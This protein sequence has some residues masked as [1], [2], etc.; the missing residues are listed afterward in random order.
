VLPD[1]RTLDFIWDTVWWRR[2]AY[3]ATLMSTACLLLYP[4]IFDA[5]M[6][7]ADDNPITRVAGLATAVVPSPAHPWIDS[8]RSDPFTVVLLAAMTGVF[9]LW[10]SL[11]DRRIHDRALAAWNGKSRANRFHWFQESLRQRFLA[12]IFTVLLFP[13]SAVFGIVAL[14]FD[15]SGTGLVLLLISVLSL[16]PAIVS[17]IYTYVLWRMRKLGL[18]EKTEIR[19]FGLW[20]ASKLRQSKLTAGPYRF[21]AWQILPRVFAIALVAASFVAASRI[22]FDFMDSG[23]WVCE[24]GSVVQIPK[25]GLSVDFTPDRPCQ[26]TNAWFLEKVKYRIE[27]VNSANWTDGGIAVDPRGVSSLSIGSHKLAMLPLRRMIT[28]PWFVVIA[29]VGNRGDQEYPLTTGTN[30]IT[31]TREG[32]LFLYVNEAVVGL[33]DFGRYYRDNNGTATIKITKVGETS[34]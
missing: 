23:G 31:P 3:F 19:G 30:E 34:N 16:L 26:S 5:N 14:S 32:E 15:W 25:E 13:L 11:I 21:F 22:A 27:I 8:F 4:A 33:P 7:G 29:R 12:V 24:G 2:V 17:G 10:G 6:T 18:A 9:A 20:M 28:K 1:E